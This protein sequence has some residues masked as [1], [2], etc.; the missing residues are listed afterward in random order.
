MTQLSSVLSCC[1]F[2]GP[3]H[4]QVEFRPHLRPDLSHL[5]ILSCLLPIRPLPPDIAGDGL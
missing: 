4:T 1:C 3:G 2:G 5:P